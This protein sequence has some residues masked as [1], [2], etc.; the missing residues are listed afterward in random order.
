M[1]CAWC[2]SVPLV[3][4]TVTGDVPTGAESAPFNVTVWLAPAARENGADGELVIP[5]GIPSDAMLTVP[6]KPFSAVTEIVRGEVVGAHGGG[7]RRGRNRSVEVRD[8]RRRGTCLS[9]P[10]KQCEYDREQGK[11][12]AS[13]FDESPLRPENRL[14]FRG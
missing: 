2:D 9:A 11:K 4:S 13:T 6:L 12:Q 10:A 1:N 3:A 7:D 5:G 14:A 8:W